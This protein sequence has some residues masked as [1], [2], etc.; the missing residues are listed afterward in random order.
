MHALKLVWLSLKNRSLTAWLTILSISLSVALL[1]GVEKIRV[2]ARQ[3]FTNSISKTDLIVGAK[4]GT[5]QLLLYTVF[6]LG[7]ATDNI[8]YDTYK[9]IAQRPDIAWTIPISL[10]DSHR[11]FRVV[12]TNEQFYK[13]YRF[14]GDRSVSLHE[15]DWAKGVFDVTLGSEVAKKL[16]YKLGARIV[17]SHGIGDIA[18][19]HHDDKPFTVVGILKQTATPI[20]QAVYISLEG[21]EAIHLDWGDGAPPTKEHQIKAQDILKH[22]IEIKQITSFLLGAKSRVDTLRIQRDLNDFV[23]EPLMAII[24]GVALSELWDGISYAE[25]ILRVVTVFVVIVGLLGMLVAIYNSLNERRREMAILRSVGAGPW[26]IVSLMIMESTLLTGLGAFLGVGLLYGLLL[27]LAPVVE[28]EFGL[29]IQIG[30]PTIVEW[31][32]LGLVLGTG[33]LMG[34]FPAIRAY[35]NTLADGLTIRI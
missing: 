24:P 28:N 4:G 17:L 18:L 25:D 9:K 27:A 2:G 20:D 16:G 14:H 3:S 30:Y 33:V 31:T 6:R 5:L 22:N 29:Y 23:D 19:Q 15:G 13:Y 32:Y 21:I 12:G 34:I 1:L 26:K 11:G 7:S 10:G 8:S 35:R